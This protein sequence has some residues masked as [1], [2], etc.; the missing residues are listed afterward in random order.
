MPGRVCHTGAQQVDD[1]AA[2]RSDRRATA[3]AVD[4]PRVHVVA[5]AIAPAITWA[6]AA[7]VRRAEAAPELL[8]QH[9]GEEVVGGDVHQPQQHRDRR[10]GD[11]ASVACAG[12]AA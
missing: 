5:A 10:R 8:G 2:A 3:R 11:V 6:P 1:L 4:D 12:A 7:I 9:L